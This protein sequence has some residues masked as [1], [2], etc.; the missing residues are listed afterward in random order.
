MYLDY[1]SNIT[2]FCINTKK[3][4]LE[5]IFEKFTKN[6]NNIT[7]SCEITTEF[8]YKT[9]TVFAICRIIKDPNENSFKTSYTYYYNFLNTNLPNYNIC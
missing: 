2:L 4:I 8:I 3:E 7:K 9:L 1:K 6:I 5:I